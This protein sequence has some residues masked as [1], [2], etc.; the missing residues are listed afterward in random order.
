MDATCSIC[1]HVTDD[2]T[3]KCRFCG[4]PFEVVLEPKK[5][6]KV[7]HDLEPVAVEPEPVKGKGSK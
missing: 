7:D 5:N 2:S 3:G 4:T 1:G 6:K